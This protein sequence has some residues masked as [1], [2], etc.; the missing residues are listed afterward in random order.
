MLLCRCLH[1]EQRPVDVT[2]IKLM[3][4]AGVEDWTVEG[5]ARPYYPLHPHRNISSEHNQIHINLRRFKIREFE[6]QV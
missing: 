5:L 6:M 4:A 1:F 3:I 2:S